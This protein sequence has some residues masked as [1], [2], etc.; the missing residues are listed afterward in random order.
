VPDDAAPPSERSAPVSPTRLRLGVFLVFLWWIPVWL[1][2]PV[3][4]EFFDLDSQ[5]VLIGLIIV[6]T[7]VGVAG[8]LVV[9]RQI[10]RIM[11]GIPARRML[12]SVWKVLRHGSLDTTGR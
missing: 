6:Q 11:T 4:A 5:D 8:L 9:G 7:I 3:I 1:A 2:T 12:P 10:A